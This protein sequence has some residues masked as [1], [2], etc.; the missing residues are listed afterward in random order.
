[1]TYEQIDKIMK[2]YWIEKFSGC[3][4]DERPND[5][6]SDIWYGLYNEKGELV[7]GTIKNPPTWDLDVWFHDGKFFSHHNTFF[8]LTISEFNQSMKRYLIKTYNL[9]IKDVL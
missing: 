7:I 5:S 3:V 6:S 9:K 2:P 1:M 4:L 8:D